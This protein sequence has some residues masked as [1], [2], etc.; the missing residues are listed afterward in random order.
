LLQVQ[1]FGAQGEVQHEVPP[2]LN[3]S[4]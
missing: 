3:L 4:I 2:V 1:L